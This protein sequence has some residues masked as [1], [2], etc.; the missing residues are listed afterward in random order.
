[1]QT[2]KKISLAVIAFTGLLIASCSQK[3]ENSKTT[4]QMENKQ[5]IKKWY[6]AFNTKN[7]ALLESILDDKWK[8]I[9]VDP[10]HPVGKKEVGGLLKH[11]TTVFPDFHCEIKDILQDGNK[12]IVRSILTGKQNGEFSGFPS[13]G[14]SIS[15]QAID[16]HEFEN[17]K[18]I[19]TWHT[20]DWMS[21]L[22]QLG[23]L[24]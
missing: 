15:I 23:H 18:I 19:N 5:Q 3:K 4:E 10:D 2:L 12:V 17:G 14:K 16:I 24:K 6:E 7:A 9:P 8:D 1:M 13:K 22:K 21:G 11:L 20:E